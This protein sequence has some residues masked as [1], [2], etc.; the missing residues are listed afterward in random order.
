MLSNWR[1]RPRPIEKSV[2]QVSRITGTPGKSAEG[3][4]VAA[5]PVLA[6]DVWYHVLW[7]IDQVNG[8]INIRIDNGEI[9]ETVHAR[10]APM[11][12]VNTSRRLL[13]KADHQRRSSRKDG[14]NRGLPRSARETRAN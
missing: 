8:T 4:T 2:E 12:P 11:I 1:N 9:I 6:P 14:M 5:G 7:W 3:E 10:R 13:S